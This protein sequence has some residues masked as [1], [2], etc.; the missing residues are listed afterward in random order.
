ME[1]SGPRIGTCE[2]NVSSADCAVK[3]WVLKSRSTL[4]ARASQHDAY[5]CEHFWK[6]LTDAARIPFPAVRIQTRACR[7]QAQSLIEE[8]E[9]EKTFYNE[10]DAQYCCRMLHS[11]LSKEYATPTGLVG[12]WIG[13]RAPGYS[14]CRCC[15]SGRMLKVL[16]VYEQSDRCRLLLLFRQVRSRVEKLKDGVWPTVHPANADFVRVTTIS[17]LAGTSNQ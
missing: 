11:M 14:S 3:V 4:K 10:D 5:G 12:S 15:C 9:C 2:P 8:L 6:G 16:K 7:V 13:L 17:L 1:A